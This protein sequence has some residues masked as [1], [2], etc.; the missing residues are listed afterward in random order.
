MYIYLSFTILSVEISRRIHLYVAVLTIV[1]SMNGLG[2]SGYSEVN[3]TISSSCDLV[4]PTRDTLFGF[5]LLAQWR[6][7]S[8]V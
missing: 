8:G 4:L 3:F 5:D 2:P 1:I 7:R 6:P